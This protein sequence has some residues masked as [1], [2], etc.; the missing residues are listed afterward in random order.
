[1]TMNTVSQLSTII[2]G[3]VLFSTISRGEV[4]SFP[5]IG[6]K[7]GLL[8]QGYDFIN[9]TFRKNCLSG[10][11][12]YGGISEAIITADKTMSEENLKTINETTLNG[13][14]NFYVS[15]ADLSGKFYQTIEKNRYSLTISWGRIVKGKSVLFKDYALSKDGK[16]A[17]KSQDSG[18]K[19]LLCG[20]GMV[21]RI[22]LGATVILTAT[23]YFA[24]D[25]LKEEMSAKIKFKL[26]NREKIKKVK[27]SSEWSNKLSRIK[28]DG[29]QIGGEPK[30]LDFLLESIEKTECTL[31]DMNSCFEAID[32][33][34][35]YAFGEEGLSAQLHDLK[36]SEDRKFAP[37][38]YHIIPYK[39]FIY[40]EL[41]PERDVDLSQRQETMKK[42]NNI[43]LS[44]RTDLGKIKN[45]T[46]SKKLSEEE[47]D[48]LW[49]IKEII[50][51]N[52]SEIGK[53]REY[54]LNSPNNCRKYWSELSIDF[55]DPTKLDFPD[56]LQ[57]YCHWA[58]KS[59]SGSKL[60][61]LMN[62][63]YE[64]VQGGCEE[65]IKKVNEIVDLNLSNSN[66]D[67]LS[68]IKY[69]INLKN[70]DASF[71][72]LSKSYDFL[73]LKKLKT[74][75]LRNND[76]ANINILSELPELSQLNLSYN[77]IKNVNMLSNPLLKNLKL[78]GNP[79]TYFS[80]LE[81]R[82]KEFDLL[83]LKEPE[84]CEWERER[85]KT[86]GYDPK[87]IDY[88]RS[89]SFAPWYKTPHDYKSGVEY[90]KHCSKIA[91]K[92]L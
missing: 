2:L 13:K 50:E 56:R 75:N 89:I 70:L 63:L 40:P 25:S 14:V 66:I 52:L 73:G 90:W 79:L 12:G 78:H 8:G 44:N 92:Y 16:R 48:N 64:N 18:L 53:T 41:D 82:R 91:P 33:L 42:L 49:D 29:F 80:A 4:L 3:L 86:T 47:A 57:D 5:A 6:I 58:N 68:P 1:M 28:F 9:N 69:F 21:Q 15:S 59:Q 83:T 67:T 38:F 37:L 62:K 54:C 23:F 55:Y 26:I 85:L 76:F 17:I 36:Y 19:S 7:K 46:Q 81:K 43:Y 32:K 30:K 35:Q 34:H 31:E 84:Y 45:L 24:N 72:N 27:G 39:D 87:V 10:S 22:D 20:D 74:L 77:R 11:F 61:N 60:K 51:N 88:N 71:N 65:L